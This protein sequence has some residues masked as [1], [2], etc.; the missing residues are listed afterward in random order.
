MQ[1]ERLKGLYAITDS[2][3]T[4]TTNLTQQVELAL[5]GGA[6]I[7]QYRDKGSDPDQR[8]TQSGALL[9]LCRKYTALLIINDD[10]ELTVEVGADGVHLGKNDPNISS[11]RASLGSDAIIG[12]SCYNRLDLAITAQKQGADYVAFGRFFPSA[13]KPQAV[14]ADTR[15]LQQASA[16]LHIP[17]IAIGGITPEN[18]RPLIAAGADMLAAIHGVFGQRDISAACKQFNQLFVSNKDSKL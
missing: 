13:T 8:S 11:A 2:G 17:I 15:L 6:R 12:V 9:Q 7:I 3:L 10:V 5:A 18:G 4:G 16:L 14:Q 1:R